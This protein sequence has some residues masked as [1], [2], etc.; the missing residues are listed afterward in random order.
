MSPELTPAEIWA[1][2]LEKTKDVLAP[3]THRTWLEPAEAVA[4]TDDQLLLEVENQFAVDYI[5]GQFGSLLSRV[6]RDTFNRDLTVAFR[7]RGR[8]GDRGEAELPQSTP[9]TARPNG[10]L[11]RLN[12]RYTFESWVVGKGNQFASAAALAVAKSPAQAYNPFFVYGGVGLGKTHL[13]QAIGNYVLQS[14]PFHKVFYVSAETFM[15]EMIH[16]IQVGNPIEF[17]NKYRQVDLLLIDDIQFLANQER[18]QEEFFH[19]FNSLYEAHKQIVLTSD[20]PPK[21]ILGVEERLIS[22]F[23]WGLVTDIQ[24]PDL[25]TRI[26]ILQKKAERENLIIPQEVILFLAK[27]IKSNVRELEGSLVRLLAHASLTGDE[28]T[29][30]LAHDVLKNLLRHEIK[31]VTV[32]RIMREVASHYDISLEGMKS[33]RRTRILAFPRQV[34]MYLCRQLTDLPLTE[35]GQA[36]GGRDHTTVLHA[37]GKINQLG[38]EDSEFRENLGRLQEEISA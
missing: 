8:K 7:H 4:L 2:I 36:F 26:A 5:E 31:K 10:E 24:P 22:R 11:P 29:V 25:E 9:P 37:C 17:R 28:I 18:T 1:V 38:H 34:A 33:K 20:R 27:H 23:Q 35:I 13:M 3:Q 32:D 14:R 12:A 16:S 30:E 21:D 6:A 19:T 15:N